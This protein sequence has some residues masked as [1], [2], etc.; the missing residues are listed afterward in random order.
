MSEALVEDRPRTA[1]T[2]FTNARLVL[3]DEVVHGTLAIADGKITGID[4]GGARDPAAIDLAGALLVPGLVDVHTDNLE[5]HFQPRAGVLWDK[6]A[7]AIAHDGQ[8]AAA[9]ITTVFDSLTVGA[10]QGWDTRAE[11][12]EPMIEGLEY[13]RDHAMLRVDHKLHLRCEITHPDIVALFEH[14]SASPLTAMMSVMDHA[15]GDRQSPDIE[16]YRKRYQ[17]NPNLSPEEVEA[18]IDGLIEGSKV[19]GPRNARA[20]AE[21]ARARGIPLATHDDRTA[22]HI[23]EAVAMGAVLTEF[24]T[25]LE[26]AEAAR[27]RGLPTL[28]GSPNLIRGSS[29]S[30]NV[31][32]AELARAGLLDMFASDYIPAS[33]LQAALRLT[34]DDF[35]FSVPRA[36]AMVSDL[37]AEALRLA[38]RGRLEVGRRA[39]LVEVQ[40]VRERPIVRSVWSAGRRVA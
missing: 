21:R 23:V 4:R 34:A 36:V 29:H 37:P 22:D 2:V 11:M 30:G 17:K 1:E 14:H 33:L 18:H 39:D 5:R 15:P 19:Y 32:A 26:A 13:A 31:A 38:D 25:T 27:A 6:V 12:I 35:G 40:L 20:L 3:A 28:M 8:V 7:A 9:G 10:A 24:P 16:A